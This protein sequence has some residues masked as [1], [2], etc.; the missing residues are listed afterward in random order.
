M[1]GSATTGANGFVPVQHMNGSAWNGQ[2]DGNYFIPTGY[3]YNIGYGSLVW[4][5]PTTGFLRSWAD[6]QTANLVEQEEAVVGVF[7]GADYSSPITQIGISGPNNKK[8]WVAGTQI[9]GSTIARAYV[10][11]DTTVVY[12]AQ[13][14]SSTGFTQS[15]GTLKTYN[16][17]IQTGGPFGTAPG[18]TL[19]PDGSSCMGID[20]ADGVKT[21]ATAPI[22]VKCIDPNP[23]NNLTGGY[24]NALCLIQNSVWRAGGNMPS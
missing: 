18:E 12:T 5:D 7:Q 23:Q 24:N 4:V 17:Y 10:I 1:Q 20:L 21:A 22:V 6:W 16:V 19:N 13:C 9:K 11:T 3:T 15:T 14:N 8:A 2:L